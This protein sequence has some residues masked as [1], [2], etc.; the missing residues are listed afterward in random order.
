MT[1]T[2]FEKSKEI[3]NDFIQSIVFLDDKAYRDSNNEDTDHDFDA[4]KISQA[5][6]K[7]KKI[8]A[9]YCPE[10]KEDI[11]CFKL[12]GEK[13]DVV[14][15]DW[16]IPISTPVVAGEEEKDEPADD[17]R[18]KY[19]KD[20]IQ[21]IVLEE[22]KTKN[23]LKL[24]VIYTGDYTILS[25]ISEQVYKDIF[26]SLNHYTHNPDDFSINSPQIKILVR[27]KYV[28][29]VEA[30]KELYE[31]HMVKYEDLPKIILDEFTGMTAGLLSNF[32]LMALTILRKNS[33]KILSLFSKEIDSAYLSHKSLLPSQEDAEDLLIEL[34][35]DTISDLLS[36]NS[37]NEKSG[38]LVQDWINQN[39]K[40]EDI[41]VG[42]SGD[43]IIK[44]PRLLL[45]LLNSQN[46]NIDER[47][48]AAINHDGKLSV[49]KTK[50]YRK[51][52]LKNNT[53]LFLN[54]DTK[55]KIKF[56]D[57]KFSILTHHKSLFMPNN[58]SPI[59]T[60]GTIIRSTKD[61]NRYYVC[62]QQKCDSVRIK[63]GQERRF[64]FIPLEVSDNEKFDF[65]T[66]N[67]TFLKKEKH[68]FSIRTIKFS[69]QDE[70]GVIRATFQEGKYLFKQI[71]EESEQ[72]EWVVDLKDLHAQRI[73]NEYASKLSRVGLDESEWHR[74]SS[75]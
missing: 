70:T 31:R 1:N 68:S 67:E 18:G 44:T 30:N 39:I 65:L 32:A 20:I 54:D 11:S 51:F 17:P 14:V 4:L 37:L 3:A 34:F 45:A 47:Y 28:N 24:I 35:G 42:N 43:T 49:N 27:A 25:N 52:L 2:F 61:E 21:S 75:T 29:V 40:E 41:G 36:Y 7:E 10:S 69:C 57:K 71:Y 22:G 9:V 58:V 59:L 48:E 33:S 8:C 62:I 64:L 12:I 38:N 5:F 73:V 13:A 53:R 23:A 50:D 60:L 46:K 72:F 63:R 66:P 56:L 55:D 16:Q 15:L 26:E 19:T 6:A 74:R